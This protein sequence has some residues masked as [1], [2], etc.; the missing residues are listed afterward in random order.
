MRATLA[1]ALALVCAGCVS[2]NAAVLDSSVSYQK[3]CPDGV[4][5]FTSA[6]RVPGPYQEVALLNS[7][8]ESGWTTEKGMAHS[9]QQKAAQL[10]A[11]GIIM[12]DTKEPNA[13]TKIIGSILGTGAER[14]GRAVAIF[15]P[16][17]SLRVQRVCRIT[18]RALATPYKDPEQAVAAAPAGMGVAPQ[19]EATQPAATQAAAPQ[20]GTAPASIVAAPAPI[21]VP[22]SAGPSPAAAPATAPTAPATAAPI[23]SSADPD[24]IPTGARYVGDAR[25]R[26]YYPVG[27]ARQH[28]V[29]LESR[30]FF[31]TADGAA[32]D[33]F[34]A[35]GDC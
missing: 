9:Q 8:G 12:G 25:I 30:V 3:I 19:A 11:N 35:S 5:I 7:S 1:V 17:D 18:P 32:R 22:V 31:Q 23:T 34:V 2:T 16:S 20:Y 33:G 4:Q 10:G 28:P 26:I 14:K 27:C 29:P 6:E 13:G 24:E 15:I 21:V